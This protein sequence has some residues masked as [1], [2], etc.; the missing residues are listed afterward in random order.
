VCGFG[1]FRDHGGTLR[2]APRL[3]EPIGRLTFKLSFRGR[4]LVVDARREHATYA[5]RAGEPLEIVHHGETVELGRDKPVTRPITP[6][7]R[8]D[9]PRQPRGREPRRRAPER[10]GTG[11]RAAAD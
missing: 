1:G 10:P 11:E 6:A 8:R 7:P 3:P 4:C 9:R 5:L 2:F